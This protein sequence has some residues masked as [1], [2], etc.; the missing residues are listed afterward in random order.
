MQEKEHV[1]EVL[2]NTKRAAK[3]EDIIELKA[4]S[5]QT[6]H[7]ASIEQDTDNVIIA[8]LIYA[9]SKLIERKSRYIARDYEAYINH[10]ISMID[11]LIASIKINDSKMFQ[12]H[13]KEMIS[14][15][16]KISDHLRRTIEDLFRKARIN[17]ASRIYEH[18]LSMGTTARLLDI[19]LWELAE[20]SG[21]TG[22]ADVPLTQTMDVK[23]RVKLA[24]E[25][26]S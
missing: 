1:L 17:K 7:T 9:L 2:Q 24:M 10:Y 21:Q 15:R 18:G 22:I 12:Q 19:S 5:D 20:Y 13:L 3:N 6:I 16:G 26:F 14:G 11:E 23:K 4:L 8:V 25:M